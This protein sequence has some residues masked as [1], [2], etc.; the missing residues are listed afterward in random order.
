MEGC[1]AEGQLSAMIKIVTEV[2]FNKTLA[3]KASIESERISYRTEKFDQW[4]NP[5]RKRCFNHGYPWLMAI[6]H[7]P[8]RWASSG[9]LKKT[10]PP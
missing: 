4:E 1:R 2:L 9:H 5:A 6:H 7:D 10:P 3:G 8:P